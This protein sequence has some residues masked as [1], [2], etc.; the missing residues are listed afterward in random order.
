MNGVF[1]NCPIL[2]FISEGCSIILYIYKRNIFTH[3]SKHYVLSHGY[4]AG[5]PIGRQYDII[6]NV[7]QSLLYEASLQPHYFSDEFSY[8]TPP[9]ET[10]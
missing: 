1:L 6:I 8:L 7:R 4:T 2:Y 3:I 5:C 10:I 9:S